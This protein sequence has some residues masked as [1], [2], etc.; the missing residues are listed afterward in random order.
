MGYRYIGKRLAETSQ[1]LQG[2]RSKVYPLVICCVY[3]IER[4][5]LG[6]SSKANEVGTNIEGI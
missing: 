6:V 5:Q 3:V 1:Q 4:F 2:V